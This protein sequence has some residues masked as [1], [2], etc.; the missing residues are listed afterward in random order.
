MQTP[1]GNSINSKFEHT[2]QQS[3][4][5]DSGTANFMVILRLRSGM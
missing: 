3:G 4:A 5:V 1:L 2:S